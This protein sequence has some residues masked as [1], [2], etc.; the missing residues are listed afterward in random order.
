MADFTGRVYRRLQRE[1]ASRIV[2]TFEDFVRGE[3]NYLSVGDGDGSISVVVRNR[4][5]LKVRGLDV[6]VDLPQRDTSVPLDT[7]DGSRMP[8]DDNSFDVVSAIF[9]LHHCNDVDQVLSEMVR[10]ARKKVVILE[11]IYR[12]ALERR[13][14]CAMDYIEN[15]AISADMNIPFNFR[16]AQEWEQAFE[17][18]GLTVEKSKCFKILTL[19][20]VRHQA[21]WIVKP[22]EGS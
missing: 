10:V 22:T 2:D 5:G 12:N 9:V 16:S 4:L 8:Y 21:F 17:D 7:Y 20:P 1:R 14:V 11:D 13:I 19:L 15:R 18:R 3:T 6:H